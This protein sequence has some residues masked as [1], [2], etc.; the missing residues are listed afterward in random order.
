MCHDFY[1]DG[2][3][4]HISLQVGGLTEI[5]II[6]IPQ[7]YSWCC[8]HGIAPL[9]EFTQFIWWMQTYRQVAA[10]PQTMTVS[11]PV[12]AIIHVHHRHFIITQPKGLYSF[13]HPTEGRRLSR[14]RH[15]S[16]GAQPMP[17][18]VY[19]S[20]CHDKHNRPRWD[21]NLGPFTLQSDALTTRS[22]R[23]AMRCVSCLTP[24]CK[25][26]ILEWMHLFLCRVHNIDSKNFRLIN[27]QRMEVY[28]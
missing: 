27:K 22:L 7:R 24:T 6:I 8:H 2:D 19:R 5:I 3:M 26:W 21:S 25:N 23:P 9:Q 16:K 12:A 4:I 18:T 1:T 10:N 17:K 14:P 15:C 11:P 28:D 13:Y 20:G